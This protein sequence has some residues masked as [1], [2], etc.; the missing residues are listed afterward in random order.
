M[1]VTNTS[2]VISEHEFCFPKSARKKRGERG[3]TDLKK[4][5]NKY[6][7]HHKIQIT[8]NHLGEPCGPKACKL[9]NFIGYLVKGKDVSMAATS[10]RK[11]PIAQKEKLWE[12]IK[13]YFFA[14]L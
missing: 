14:L 13:V 5:W 9:A 10:W 4:F 1:L 2:T 12:T 6:G 3:P 7:P 8:L 11:V